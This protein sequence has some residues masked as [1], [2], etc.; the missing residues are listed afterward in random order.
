[1]GGVDQWSDPIGRRKSGRSPL[2]V[3]I[4]CAIE[5]TARRRGERTGSANRSASTAAL[6]SAP[7]S[8]PEGGPVGC[9]RMLGR[10]RSSGDGPTRARWDMPTTVPAPRCSPPSSGIGNRIARQRHPR[11]ARKQRSVDQRAVWR[12]AP[13]RCKAPFLYHERPILRPQGTTWM[14]QRQAHTA[15]LA[16]ARHLLSG[17]RSP[18]SDPNLA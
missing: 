4:S 1:M 13:R 8:R 16:I 3:S 6:C 9:G 18:P 17:L 2:I 10:S 11:A 7:V 5:V 15:R 12:A 14:R